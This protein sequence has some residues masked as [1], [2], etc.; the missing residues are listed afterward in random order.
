MIE[1]PGLLDVVGNTGA[2]LHLC[3]GVLVV[4]ALWEGVTLATEELI[5]LCVM[6]RLPMLLVIT[7]QNDFFLKK[8]SIIYT[9]IIDSS[10]SPSHTKLFAFCDF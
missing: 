8:S 10:V 4:V 5:R 7:G 9:Y 1:C 2:A 6:G 3:D